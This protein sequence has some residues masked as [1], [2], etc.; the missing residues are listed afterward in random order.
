M[1]AGQVYH[2]P[3]FAEH[4]YTAVPGD[5]LASIAQRFGVSVA[6]LRAEN[7]LSR[8]V[9]SVRSGQKIFLPDGYRDR[10]APAPDRSGRRRAYRAAATARRTICRRIRQPYRPAG[11][12]GPIRFRLSARRAPTPHADASAHRRPDPAARARAASS[13]R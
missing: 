8:R 4:F 11:A 12:A 7:E 1:H 3:S 6:S 10:E 9:L 13:G 5:T 2:G